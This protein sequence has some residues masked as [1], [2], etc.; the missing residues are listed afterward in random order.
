MITNMFILDFESERGMY[1][2][3]V[4]M[5]LLISKHTWVVNLHEIIMQ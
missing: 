3:F 5:V 4:L 1:Y 2:S